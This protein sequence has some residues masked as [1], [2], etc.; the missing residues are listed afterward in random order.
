MYLVHTYNNNLFV[1]GHLFTCL[2]SRL[3]LPLDSEPLECSVWNLFNLHFSQFQYSF[4]TQYGRL[5][6]S[7]QY[8]LTLSV[9]KNHT[10]LSHSCQVCP[11][12]FLGLMKCVSLQ[13]SIVRN[14]CVVPLCSFFFLLPDRHIPEGNCSFR[15][16]LI[17]RV[18][19]SRVIGLLQWT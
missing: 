4:N 14:N 19:W 9:E 10:H 13:I 15:L 6:F 3:I 7:S 17:M 11:Y 12:D 1:C 18:T 5:Y 8:S 2:S 16:G